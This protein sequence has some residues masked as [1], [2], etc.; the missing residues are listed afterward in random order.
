MVKLHSH[1]PSREVRV[2]ICTGSCTV[3]QS[4]P[5]SPCKCWW[6]KVQ[7]VWGYRQ[8]SWRACKRDHH[9]HSTYWIWDSKASLCSYWLSWTCWLHKKHA[10]WYVRVTCIFLT[11]ITRACASGM[12]RTWV[13]MC[14]WWCECSISLRHQGHFCITG[15][16]V[17]LCAS[18]FGLHHLSFLCSAL[19]IQLSMLH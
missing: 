15:V 1:Q 13:Y 8:C 12:H 17:V 10:Y 2:L 6:C 14:W 4:F 3:V 18:F 9:F 5:F 7:I 19:C 16:C 11:T